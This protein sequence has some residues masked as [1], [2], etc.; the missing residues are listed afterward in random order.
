MRA[1]SQMRVCSFD[2]RSFSSLS[3]GVQL[4]MALQPC[5]MEDAVFPFDSLERS[6]IIVSGS[7]VR[8]VVLLESLQVGV[9]KGIVFCCNW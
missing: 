6:R 7:G 4:S 3:V 5:L 1:V 8:H 9:G 2:W